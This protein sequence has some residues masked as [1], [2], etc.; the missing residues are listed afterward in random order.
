MLLEKN[1]MLLMQDKHAVLQEF[2][3][4][5][6]IDF[7]SLSTLTFS[8]VKLN[9]VWKFR[10]SGATFSLK[11]ACLFWSNNVFLVYEEHC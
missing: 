2:P 3:F 7:F 5:I 1:S 9:F 11:T 8:N 4:Y 6:S 10:L